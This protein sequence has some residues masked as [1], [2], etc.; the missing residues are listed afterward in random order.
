MGLFPVHIYEYRRKILR[1]VHECK[2]VHSL[3]RT[4]VSEDDD[5]FLELPVTVSV[6]I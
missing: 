3:I 1:H 2:K 6:M 5:D 4:I